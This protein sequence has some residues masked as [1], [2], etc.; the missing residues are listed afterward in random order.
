MQASSSH[1]LK[2][3]KNVTS[4][5]AVGGICLACSGLGFVTGVLLLYLTEGP[6]SPDIL[7]IL[8]QP[9]GQHLFG[10]MVAAFSVAIVFWVIGIVTLFTYL[11]EANFYSMLVV[12]ALNLMTSGGVISFLG[13]QYAL[14]AL[15]KEGIPVTDLGYKDLSIVAHAAADLG[16]WI[17]IA[18]FAFSILIM[19]LLF[20]RRV[21][22]KVLGYVGF[23]FV[24]IAVILFLLDVSYLFLIAF[25]LWELIVA[26]TVVYNRETSPPNK[27]KVGSSGIQTTLIN[28]Q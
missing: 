28:H 6:G 14:V 5:W 21:K 4:L 20:S 27:D 11:K 25:G 7:S 3:P 1:S 2:A 13:L 18:I 26:A 22:W 15:G 19:S 17:T 23:F 10:G 9:G 24:V 8:V 12:L 16:G